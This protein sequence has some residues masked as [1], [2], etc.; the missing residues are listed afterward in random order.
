MTNSSEISNSGLYANIT[1]HGF[2]N[3]KY[4]IRQY[5]VGVYIDGE[6]CMTEWFDDLS[7]AVGFAEGEGITNIVFAK[8]SSRY[9]E[10]ASCAN[11][12]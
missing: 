11:T 1:T 3:L 9:K 12:I 6:H 8:A 5:S 7:K 2:K 4:A 10:V